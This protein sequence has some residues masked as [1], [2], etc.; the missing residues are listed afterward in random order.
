[1]HLRLVEQVGGPKKPAKAKR[2][3]FENYTEVLKKAARE[4]FEMLNRP[5][6]VTLSYAFCGEENAPPSAPTI[7][8]LYAPMRC[9]KPPG[10]CQLPHFTLH[11]VLERLA[12]DLLRKGRG[13]RREQKNGN[14]QQHRR[15]D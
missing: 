13:K 4:N 15:P 1:M 5:V 2:W 7:A 9:P 8:D 11:Q 14:R 6:Q 12:D 10:E 3:K